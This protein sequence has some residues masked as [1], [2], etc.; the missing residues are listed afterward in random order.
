MLDK[1]YII[2]IWIHV[3][4]NKCNKDSNYDT[5]LK[6]CYCCH[7]VSQEEIAEVKGLNQQ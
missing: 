1:S 2:E 3:T 6:S 4:L 5:M 7:N